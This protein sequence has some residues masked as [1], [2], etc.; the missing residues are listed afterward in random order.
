MITTKFLGG[1][2]KIFATDKIEL[3]FDNRRIS[4]LLEYLLQNKPETSPDFDVNNILIA[5]NGMDS[6]AIDG[7]DTMLSSG[8]IVTIIPVIHGGSRL[9]LKFGTYNVELFDVKKNDNLELNLDSLREK[10]PKLLL[11]TISSKF[12]LGRN[13]AQKILHLSFKSQADGL[14]LSKKLETDI[15]MRFAATNQISQAISKIGTKQKNDFVVIA[16]GA[17][18]NLDKIH[19]FL[20]PYLNSKPLSQNNSNFLKK[21]FGVTKHQLDCVNSKTPLEDILVEKASILF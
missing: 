6:S 18:I 17:K 1:A 11:Q 3:D 20:K 7:K 21:E 19:Q 9:Q 13:H 4:E 16:I 14:L 8:D 10:F 2:K 5:V 12:L 15:L